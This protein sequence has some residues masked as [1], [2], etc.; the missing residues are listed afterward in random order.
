MAQPG[1]ACGWLFVGR[2]LMAAII[3]RRGTREDANNH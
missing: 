1:T 3:R 2:L